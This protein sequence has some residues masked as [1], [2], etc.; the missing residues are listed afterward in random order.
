MASLTQIAGPA[1][2]QTDIKYLESL[3][4]KV[5]QSAVIYGYRGDC[6]QLPARNAVALPPLA[7]GTLTVGKQGIKD[8]GRCG[9]TPAVEIIFTATAPGRESFEVQGDKITVRVKK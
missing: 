2:A 5:G 4:L 9:L 1:S 3:S 6:G 7:T 8:S